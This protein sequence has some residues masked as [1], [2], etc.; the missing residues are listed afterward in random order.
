MVEAPES[1]RRAFAIG[2]A[3]CVFNT[4]TGAVQPV[5][6]RYGALNLDPLLFCAA[7]VSIAAV[8]LGFTLYRRGELSALFDRRYLPRLLSISIAGTVITSLTLIAGLR[9]IEAVAGVLLLQSEPVYSLVLSTMVVGER[10]SVRQLGATATIVGGIGIVFVGGAFSPAWAAFLVVLTPFFWQ[11]SHVVS[12]RVMPPLGPIQIAGA[13][14]IY[15]AFVLCAILFAMRPRAIV[16]LA[17]PTALAVVAVTGVFIYFLGTSSWYA[18]ISRLSL[19]WTT[20]LVVPGIPLLSI[21]FA[22]IVLGERATAREVI[23]ILVAVC[24][25][26]ALVTGADPHRQVPPTEAAEAIHAPLT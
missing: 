26:V 19:A 21:L 4:I 20:A 12:L 18:A 25:V 2:V 17:D 3:L 22:V 14:Y 9:R 24:G 11:I 13:R 10:P 6:T 1:R 7:C 5:I 23:G 15:A 8:C 16:E